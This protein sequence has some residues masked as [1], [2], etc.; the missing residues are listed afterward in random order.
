[1]VLII[2]LI[3]T[4]LATVALGLLAGDRAGESGT[5][6]AMKML[7]IYILVAPVADA[8]CGP[9]Y[10]YRQY[11]TLHSSPYILPGDANLFIPLSLSIEESNQRCT[12]CLNVRPVMF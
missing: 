6:L 12:R 4:G 5:A 10:S 8:L 9:F 1:M 3:G 2:A 11:K 7:A